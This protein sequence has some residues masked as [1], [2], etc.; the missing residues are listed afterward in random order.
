VEKEIPVPPTLGGEGTVS[1]KK[2]GKNIYRPRLTCSEEDKSQEG[3]DIL[4]SGKSNAD[5]RNRASAR[6]RTFGPGEVRFGLQRGRNARSGKRLL[7]QNQRR[8]ILD[9]GRPLSYWGRGEPASN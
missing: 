8:E 6:E 7:L 1:N 2:T 9:G 3:K 5:R 4:A